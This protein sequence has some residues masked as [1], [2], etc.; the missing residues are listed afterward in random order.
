[1]ISV[2]IITKNDEEVIAD[3]IR[4][5]K[6]LADEIIVV[7]GGSE[8]RTAEVAEKLGAKVVKNK[9]KNF[10]DQ[11]N[12]AATFAHEPW[13][14]YVDSDEQATEQ[15]IREVKLKISEAER[16]SNVSGFYIRRKTYFY[17]KDWGFVDSVE[18]IFKKDKLKGWKGIVHETPQ[19]DGELKTINEPILHYTHRNLEQMVEKTNEWSDFEAEL[20]LKANH[21]EMSAWRFGRVILTAF[22]VSYFKEG[23]YK[24]GT[25]GIIEAIYQAFSMFITYAKLWEKQ[26]GKS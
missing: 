16:S 1:M 25:A 23:G 19:V 2:L 9:F 12:L 11:R 13:I 21:P 5:V 26:R 3:C 15:F 8:D 7:D 10:S 20:R 6:D 22:L 14:F 4:S 18:R 17:G 24:N